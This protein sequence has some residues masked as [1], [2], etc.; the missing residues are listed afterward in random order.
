MKK[1]IQLII[2]FFVIAGIFTACSTT[3]NAIGIDTINGFVR[4]GKWTT[5]TKEVYAPGSNTAIKTHVLTDGQYL[6]FKNDDKAHVYN[7][8][9]TELSSHSYRFLDTKTMLYD[10]VEYKVQENFVSTISIMTLVNESA[11]GKTV[12]IFNR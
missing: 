7:S 10:G 6:E 5:L 11:T 2:A 12:L 1:G 9:G 3:R 8:S 4:T